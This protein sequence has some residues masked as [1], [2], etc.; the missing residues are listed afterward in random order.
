VR[1]DSSGA[2]GIWDGASPAPA[3]IYKET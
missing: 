2:G 1:A 3:A